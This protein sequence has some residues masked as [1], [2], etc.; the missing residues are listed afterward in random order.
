MGFICS[1]GAWLIYASQL[2]DGLEEFRDN[3]AEPKPLITGLA[4]GIMTGGI[5]CCI[6]SLCCG[7]C[8]KDRIEEEEWEKCR[9]VCS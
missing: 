1:V 8:D 7:G 2:P 4:T 6:I 5:A 3:T 9:R